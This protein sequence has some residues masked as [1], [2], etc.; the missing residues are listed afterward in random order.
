[1][2]ATTA[3]AFAEVEHVMRPTHR[4]ELREAAGLLPAKG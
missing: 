1:L 4:S 3:L 2:G